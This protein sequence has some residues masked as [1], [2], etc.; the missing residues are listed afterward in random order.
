M[1]RRTFVQNLGK[2]SLVAGLMSGWSLETGNAP[3]PKHWWFRQARPEPFALS[4]WS[5]G[6]WDAH[7]C[8]GAPPTICRVSLQTA[9]DYDKLLFDDRRHRQAPYAT[10]GGTDVIGE[11]GI[12]DSMVVWVHEKAKA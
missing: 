1:D 5:K 10:F 6:W 4:E 8:F 2:G 7:E 9:K 12:P 3:F 11:S